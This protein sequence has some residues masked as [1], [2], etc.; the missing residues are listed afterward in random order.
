MKYHFLFGSIIFVSLFLSVPSLGVTYAVDVAD[1][2]KSLK[3]NSTLTRAR[4]RV[5]N[6]RI[7]EGKGTVS[8]NFSVPIN[9]GQEYLLGFLRPLEGGY[10]MTFKSEVPVR[11]K[12]ILPMIEWLIGI[13]APQGVSLPEFNCS[14]VVSEE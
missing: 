13:V 5:L 3:W 8:V 10:V 4:C 2:M 12:A 14:N 7:I 9:G 1:C 11:D 6:G